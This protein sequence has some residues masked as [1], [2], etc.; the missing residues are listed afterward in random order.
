MSLPHLRVVPNLVEQAYATLAAAISSGE[1]APGHRLTQEEL[2]V[3]LAVSRQPVLQALRL[4]KQEGMVVDA[5]AKS[6][7]PG[8]SRGLMVAPLDAAMIAGLYEVRS[9]LDGLAA[10]LAAQRGACIDSGL[11]THGRKV[12]SGADMAA[13]IDADLALHN[14]IYAASGNPYIAD[15][16]GRHWQHIRRAMGAVLRQA[17]ARMAVWDEHAAI[18]AAIHAGDADL[19]EQLAR[20]HAGDA[21]RSLHLRLMAADSAPNEPEQT[22]PR[23]GVLP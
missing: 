22:R 6:G 12:A 1:F 9:V 2:A 21:G 20:R 23:N 16:A 3:T 19:A 14:A 11:L 7:V 10:R 8:A 17:D 4:L 15:S 13:M 5:P 18:I